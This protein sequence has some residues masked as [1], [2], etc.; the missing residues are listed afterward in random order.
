LRTHYQRA[1]TPARCALLAAGAYE[2]KR[3]E[4]SALAAFG[5]L[6]STPPASPEPSPVPATTKPTGNV[7]FL[8]RDDAVQSAI[9]AGHL[10]PGRLDPEYEAREVV[11]RAFG[12][13]FTSRLNSNLR[14]RHGYTYGAFSSLVA[15]RDLGAWFLSSSVRA[16]ST[17]Q[18]VVEM[19]HEIERLSTD[20]L[21]PDEVTRATADL[22]Q[23]RR[24]R[25]E[26]DTLLLANLR[27]PFAFDLSLAHE[28]GYASRLA[29]LTSP[30]LASAARSL[31]EAPFVTVVV[32]APAQAA[33][34]REGGF[35]VVAAD[36][37]W[38]E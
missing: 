11:D 2:A 5:D 12:G 36:P 37:N 7:L 22:V 29:A 16:D 9:V 10:V 26:H 4:N 33:A 34:L 27:E 28:A 20:P 14:E 18:A 25:L 23:R 1:V 8:E 24:A 38:L 15:H 30:A 3:L 6:A 19:D 17:A 32:A 21:G 31:A 35:E 13:L